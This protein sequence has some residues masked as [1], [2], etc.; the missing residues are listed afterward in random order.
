MSETRVLMGKIQALRQRL[1]QAQGLANEARSAAAALVEE[2]GGERRLPAFEQLVEDSHQHDAQLD[3]V[4]RPRTAVIRHDEAHGLPRQL[5]SRARRCLEHGRNLLLHLRQLADA[6]DPSEGSETPPL[7]DRRDP[8]ARL[9]RETIALTDTAL[10]MTLLFPESASAQLRLCEGLEAILN[11]VA[12]RQMTLSAGVERQRQ[13][14]GR[15]T[16]LAELL[17]A[18]DRGEAVDKQPFLALAEDIL[19]DA[20]ECGPLRFLEGD[21]RRPAHFAACHDLTTARIVGRVIRHD[22]ELRG[23]PLDAL[24]AA[25]V[26]DVGMLRIPPEILAYPEPFDDNQRRIVEAHCHVGVSVAAPLL[27]DAPWLAEVIVGHHERLDG[28]GYPDGLR[29][30]QIKPL[31]RLL[32]VCDVYAALCTRRS[33]R[34]ARETRT[35]LTDTLLLAEQGQLDRHYAE[36]LLH[37]SFYPV[38]SVV[39]LADG[40]VGVVVATPQPRRDLNSPARPVVALLM[41]GQG[42]PLPLPHHVDLAQCDSPSIVRTLSAAE[43]RQ[44]LG[45]RFPEWV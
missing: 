7:F 42:Q 31:T 29:D 40:A 34:P 26:H 41:D 19:T 25:L 27:L 43:S 9:Y 11:V 24:L 39:E 2:S 23:R 44:L 17:T 20:Q 32:A 3:S 10:R 28:T 1:E 15:V 22:P 37:L 4:V 6:F 30:F 33:H 16:R 12:A 8:L 45:G 18:L 14:V 21:P 36:C 35:A 13:E 38:G 5:T